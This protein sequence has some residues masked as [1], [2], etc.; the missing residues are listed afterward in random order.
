MT[1][2]QK[3]AHI[4]IDEL[5]K[6]AVKSNALKRILSLLLAGGAGAGIASSGVLGGDGPNLNFFGQDVN[7]PEGSNQLNRLL[8]N[9]GQQGIQGI[10]GGSGEAEAAPSEAGPSSDVLSQLRG[11]M[12]G[13][14]GQAAGSNIAQQLQG[15]TGSL[16]QAPQNVA[17]MAGDIVG[18][19]SGR[20]ASDSLQGLLSG[21]GL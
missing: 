11:L 10:F 19:M 7:I 15:L 20:N 6:T 2:R 8:G 13:G 17:G 5:Q 12:G 9:I 3:V 1:T 16:S 14:A 21:I 4:V 18:N